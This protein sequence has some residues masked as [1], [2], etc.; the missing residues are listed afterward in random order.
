V[1]GRK[2]RRERRGGEG[3]KKTRR[4]TELVSKDAKVEQD[5]CAVLSCMSTPSPSSS[6]IP[7]LQT[8]S[9][10]LHLSQPIHI[11]SYPPATLAYHGLVQFAQGIW[12]GLRLSIPEGKN[13]GTI[14]GI[15][16]FDANEKEGVFCKEAVVLVRTS[17]KSR[18]MYTSSLLSVM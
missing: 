9:P 11:Q 8:P 12:C 2:R 1:R 16:Y 5:C 7:A 6:P 4:V 10:H 3:K 13:N 14:N 17:I 15:Y 18:D